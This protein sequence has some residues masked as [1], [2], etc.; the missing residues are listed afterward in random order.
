M[1]LGWTAYTIA[2]LRLDAG[3]TEKASEALEQ[4]RTIFAALVQ[5]DPRNTSLISDLAQTY[6]DLAKLNVQRK[7]PEAAREAL[8]QAAARL[9]ELTRKQDC[10]DLYNLA[11]VHALSSELAKPDQ[12]ALH[13]GRAVE[14]LG[15]AVEKGFRNIELLKR[16]VG[17]RSLRER[18]EFTRLVSDLERKRKTN[19]S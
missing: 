13:A 14:V 4:A 7:Q 8:R 17:F 3:E 6:V 16:D 19:G 11:L 9:E 12:K 18:P 2:E 15:Q 5:K 1:D 10:S